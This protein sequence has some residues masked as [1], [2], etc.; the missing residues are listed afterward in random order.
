MN[1]ICQEIKLQKDYLGSKDLKTIYVG[2]GTPSLLTAKELEQIFY[3]VHQNFSVE[4]EAEITLEANP[5]DLTSSY[6]TAIKSLGINRLSIGI[7]S[8]RE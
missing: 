8:F 5:E 3:T 7:Q 4:T 1:A 6:L 2:G